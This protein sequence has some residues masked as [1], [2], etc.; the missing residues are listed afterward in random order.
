LGHS[1]G[2]LIACYI[3]SNSD[4]CNNLILEDPPLFSSNG[5]K[6]FD[7]YNYNDLSTVCHEFINQDEESD[8]VYYYFMNQYAWNFFPDNIREKIRR[9]SGESALKYRRKHP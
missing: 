9:K 2:G 1:S 8:F 4:V 6:R 5:D 3:A 7:Y